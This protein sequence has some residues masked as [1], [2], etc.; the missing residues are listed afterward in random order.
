V[1]IN[2][3]AIIVL[4]VGGQVSKVCNFAK[5]LS[6][7]RQVISYKLNN[8]GN[9]TTSSDDPQAGQEDLPVRRYLSIY[10]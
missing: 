10:Q 2:P 6:K 7:D 5:G 3:P 8:S 9:Q 4:C 1:G